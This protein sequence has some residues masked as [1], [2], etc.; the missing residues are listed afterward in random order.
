[1]MMMCYHCKYGRHCPATFCGLQIY[2]DALFVSQYLFCAAWMWFWT[3]KMFAVFTCL[4]RW[5]AKVLN[6]IV[7]V[8]VDTFAEVRERDVLNLAEAH[9]FVSCTSGWHTV[10]F[11]GLVW[12]SFWVRFRW[13]ILRPV[14]IKKH[15]NKVCVCV[16]GLVWCSVCRK[17]KRTSRWTKSFFRFLDSVKRKRGSRMVKT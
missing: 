5:F 4:T 16:P 3:L 17:W 1:M 11:C 14:C 10:V 9:R 15:Q 2:H 13:H 7:A 12:F 8:V 6:L